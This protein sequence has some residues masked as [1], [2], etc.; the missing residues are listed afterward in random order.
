MNLYRMLYNE[1]LI[2]N[3]VRK[4]YSNNKFELWLF[5]FLTTLPLLPISFLFF[6]SLGPP[7]QNT[8]WFFSHTSATAP[9]SCSFASSLNAPGACRQAR[10][11]L[12]ALTSA[13]PNLLYLLMLTFSRF[14]H[15]SIF[16]PNPWGSH[17]P[18]PHTTFASCR[19]SYIP[20]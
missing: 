3:Q 10:G 11:D 2:H 14:S 18:V 6:L 19:L 16:C 20:L 5:L 4:Q 17:S 9:L 12:T 15:S 1:V 13:Q 7:D 8:C